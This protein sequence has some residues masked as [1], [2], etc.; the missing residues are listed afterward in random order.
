M[1]YVYG[2]RS[3]KNLEGVH[4]NLV[5]VMKEGI[6]NCPYDITIIWGLRTAAQQNALYKKRPKVTNCDGYRLKS[7][8][9]AKSDGYGYAVDFVVLDKTKKDGF[10][11]STTSKYRAVARHFQAIAKSKGFRVD[12][13]GDWKGSWDTP[14][15]EYKGLL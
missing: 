1:A 9:Q 4:P 15:L 5:A 13:G 14:H 3:L 2:K 10:D 7:N 12:W 6:T 8:H 11:W